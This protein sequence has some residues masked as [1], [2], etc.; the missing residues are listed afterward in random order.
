VDESEI[1]HGVWGNLLV[2]LRRGC[3]PSKIGCGALRSLIGGVGLG[4]GGWTL[5]VEELL[6]GS[7]RLIE[8]LKGDGRRR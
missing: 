2:V 3:N 6:R 8:S 5:V 4:R 1:G 7:C